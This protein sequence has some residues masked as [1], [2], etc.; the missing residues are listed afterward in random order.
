M[1]YTAICFVNAY[2]TMSSEIKIIQKVLLLVI[3]LV[4]MCCCIIYSSNLKIT[5]LHVSFLSLGVSCSFSA[6]YQVLGAEVQEHFYYT[7]RLGINSRSDSS[8]GSHS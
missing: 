3:Q 2:S 5:S 4:L 1:G 8:I 7:P 6:L